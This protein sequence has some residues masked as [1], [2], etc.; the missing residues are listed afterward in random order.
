M[1]RLNI[2]FYFFYDSLIIIPLIQ[3]LP[4][5]VNINSGKAFRGLLMHD[6]D[7]G[8]MPTAYN[9]YGMVGHGGIRIDSFIIIVSC[10]FKLFAADGKHRCLS[11]SI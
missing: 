11:W 7:Q 6:S 1:W 9:Y 8:K 2:I 4:F 5:V 10:N 3:S